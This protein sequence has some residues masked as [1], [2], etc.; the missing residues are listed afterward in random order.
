MKRTARAAV[1][2]AAIAG[3]LLVIWSVQTLPDGLDAAP[4]DANAPGTAASGDDFAGV[5]WI[6][7][8]SRSTIDNRLAGVPWIE[9]EI[10][11]HGGVRLAGVPWIESDVQSHAGARDAAERSDRETGRPL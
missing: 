2:G 1:T 5:P 8:D 7:S 10:P 6:E 4:D 11:T 9:R 3:I